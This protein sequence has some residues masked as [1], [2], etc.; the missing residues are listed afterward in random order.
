[1]VASDIVWA[2][3]ILAGAAFETYAL[4]NAREGDTASE[5]TRKLF[6][7]RTS[8]AGRWV[9][10]TVW[11]AWSVWFFLHVLWDVPFPGF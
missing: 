3:L 4:R 10:G 8:R 7:V 2:A 5:A 9:F 6:R 1:M 11:A